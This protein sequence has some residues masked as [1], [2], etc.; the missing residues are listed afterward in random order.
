MEK[1]RSVLLRREK[2]EQTSEGAGGIWLLTFNDMMTLLLTFFVLILSMSRVDFSKV[3]EASTAVGNAFG[4]PGKEEKTE[5]RVF[6]PFIFSSGADGAAGERNA[7]AAQRDDGRD[8]FLE[9]RD[10]FI[11]LHRGR[12]GVTA[13]T[14]P[15]GVRVTIDK[16]I[17]FPEGEAQF[18]TARPQDLSDLCD[19]LEGARVSVR[20]SAG[21]DETPADG[22]RFPSGW[23]LAAARAARVAEF[24]VSQGGT[25]PSNLS[26]SAYGAMKQGALKSG[27]FR[28]G[29]LEVTLTY[30]DS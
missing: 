3:E 4:L 5:V 21:A 27:W 7:G 9:K 8:R 13:Q 19:L 18:R 29:G 12:S 25:D 6:D 14:I 26:V 2:R 10:A 17:L 20:V 28:H 22:A 16:G 15:Q 11:G 1:E 24:M 23:E 30:Q